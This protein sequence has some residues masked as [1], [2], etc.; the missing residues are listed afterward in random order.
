[1]NS[2]LHVGGEGF[3]PGQI[4]KNGKNGQI[5]PPITFENDYISGVPLSHSCSGA[6]I[7]WIC[8]IPG[9]LMNFLDPLLMTS[10]T[11]NEESRRGLNDQDRYF[12]E[13]LGSMNSGLHVGGEGFGPGQILKNGKNGQIDPPITFENDYISGVPLSHSCSGAQIQWICLIP[14]HL[15]NFLDPLLMTSKTQ[16]EE[17]RV[18]QANIQKQLILLISL[19]VLKIN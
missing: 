8:L 1:M 5:D 19:R 10:K 6:Q 12:R 18:V 9:H 13:F 3:G 4:L 11:Q 16:N 17:S 15:M 14:G 7:Q 2:G